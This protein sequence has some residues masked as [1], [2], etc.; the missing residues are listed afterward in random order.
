MLVKISRRLAM[1][2]GLSP[3]NR[4]FPQNDALKEMDIANSL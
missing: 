4:S 2:A 3:E 1:N